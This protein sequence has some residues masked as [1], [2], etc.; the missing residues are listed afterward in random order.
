[1]RGPASVEGSCPLPRL[2]VFG[3]ECEG[4]ATNCHPSRGRVILLVPMSSV[5]RF[6]FFIVVPLLDLRLQFV[7]RI[8]RVADC[9]RPL[10]KATT[11]LNAL[12][13][14]ALQVSELLVER[15]VAFWAPRSVLELRK[16]VLEG[17]RV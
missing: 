5:P 10:V 11:L 15:S 14:P 17:Q 7:D 16:H 3:G 12:R 9:P 2:F 1:M 13:R 6:T 4:G 8:L